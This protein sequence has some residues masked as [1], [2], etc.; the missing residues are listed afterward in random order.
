MQSKLAVLLDGLQNQ[1]GTTAEDE[2]DKGEGR[3]EK[4]NG[5]DRNQR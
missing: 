5:L 4:S 2:R 1:Y 3:N